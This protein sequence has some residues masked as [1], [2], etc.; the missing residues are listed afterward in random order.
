MI[1]AM[2]E[3]LVT[4]LGDNFIYLL[5]QG[6]LACAVDPTAA[7][8]VQRLLDEHGLTL[9][10]ILNTHHHADHVGGNE[11]LKNAYGCTVVGG[12]P[13][14]PGVD[15]VVG[16]GDAVRFGKVD[17]QVLATP[18]HT[19]DGLCFY[20]PGAPGLIFTG[21]TLFVGGCGRVLEGTAVELWRSLRRLAELPEETLVYCGHE[22]A[23]ANY[24]FAALVAGERKPLIRTRQAELET[25]RRNGG[26]SVPSTIAQEK[27]TNVFMTAEDPET[28]TA[29]RSRKDRG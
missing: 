29:L 16:D 21:D 12:S 25:R 14:I 23:K 8:P 10:L 4:S 9:M 2:S 27:A 1:F 28:F 6:H 17:F 26:F 19:R 20:R 24:A 3:V 7:E 11:T 22:Y 13:A 18:G 5:R 15:R